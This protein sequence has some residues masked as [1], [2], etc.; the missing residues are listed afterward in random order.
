[1]LV[2]GLMVV[3]LYVHLTA[4]SLGF[5]VPIGMSAGLAPGVLQVLTAAG[6]QQQPNIT[7]T[8]LNA[9]QVAGNNISQKSAALIFRNHPEKS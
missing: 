1:M 8:T 4:A 6:P 3:S 9:S 2:T 7:S 5:V